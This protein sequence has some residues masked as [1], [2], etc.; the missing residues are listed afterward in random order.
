MKYLILSLILLLSNCVPGTAIEKC[1]KQCNGKGFSIESVL[2]R[3]N[4]K[5]Q[6]GCL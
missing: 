5:C 2:G 1:S 4:C 3:F 6:G